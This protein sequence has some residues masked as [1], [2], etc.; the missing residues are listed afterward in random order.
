MMKRKTTNRIA[1]IISAAVLAATQTLPAVPGTVCA[2]A[3][4]TPYIYGT[5]DLPYA[6]YY[7]GEL[8]EVTVSDTMDLTAEDLTAAIR[9]EGMYDAVTSATNQKSKRYSSTYYTEDEE[10]G[11][12][13]VEGIADVSIA[14]PESLYHEAMEAIEA[15]S[16]CNNP[17]LRIIGSMTVY[18]DQTI[19][20]EYKIL[21]GNGTLTAMIDKADAVVVTD[22]AV[23]VTT[24]TKYGN[25]QLSITEADAENSLLPDSENMEGVVIT[26]T[27]GSSYAMLHV[28]NLWLRTGEIAW[29]VE[30]G[31]LVHNK[32]VLKYKSFVDTVG[33]TVSSVHYI[34]RG[35]A[36]VIFETASY[37]PVLHKGTVTATNADV[38]AGSFALTLAD[39]PEGFDAAVEATA[40]PGATYADGT[41]SFDAASTNPGSYDITVTDAAGVYAPM[42]ASV[43]LMTENL[44]A[45][46]DAA[47]NRIVAADDANADA[48]SNY[49]KNIR[50][51]TVGDKSY[52]AFGKGSVQI[53][54]TESGAIHLD[55][56]A[57]SDTPVFP[58][59]G[60][61]T[62]TISAAGYEN[63]LTFQLTIG[64]AI[65][66]LLG[67]LDGDSTIT[68]ADA[69]Q[70]LLE[71]SRL[72]LGN[73]GTFTDAV[74]QAADVDKDGTLTM[75]DAY[76]ILL[77]SSYVSMGITPEWNDILPD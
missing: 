15:G 38:T 63:D 6:D 32:N 67:D 9:S 1:G 20:A 48:F 71:T 3:E 70:V 5:V 60:K 56:T 37:L 49:L 24:N 44:P 75:S 29:A 62:I 65:D 59:D 22:A 68:M 47:S 53:I 12:V 40:L 21:S 50:N 7:Y 26:M 76:Y 41:V 27:D 43:T 39:L 64:E 17:L 18:E 54:D 33:K 74:C 31:F 66:I 36:D 19:P 2:L 61:Y 72:S 4:E 42:S 30:E 77:Y 23:E 35:S 34:I 14:V 69:Y 73:D 16:A 58:E 46:Y 52:N 55:A 28:D 25:Y 11:S 57:T 13:T 45:V 51:V 10:A 8:H